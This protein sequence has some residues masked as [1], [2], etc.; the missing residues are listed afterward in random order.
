MWGEKKCGARIGPDFGVRK[1][2]GP[3]FGLGFGARI[4]CGFRVSGFGFTVW[5][6]GCGSPHLEKASGLEG[7]FRVVSDFGSRGCG[8]VYTLQGLSVMVLFSAIGRT[9]RGLFA[10]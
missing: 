4:W 10:E 8:Q 2:A 7:S 6:P 9:Y 1:S 5:V 3:E